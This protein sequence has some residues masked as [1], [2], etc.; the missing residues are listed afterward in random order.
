MRA[1]GAKANGD[2]ALLVDKPSAL[3]RIARSV[4]SNCRIASQGRLLRLS[5][6]RRDA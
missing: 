2:D 1:D 3:I 6:M 4:R 5:R